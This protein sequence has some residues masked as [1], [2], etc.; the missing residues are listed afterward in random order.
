RRLVDHRLGR[1]RPGGRRAEAAGVAVVAES[2]RGRASTRVHRG[3]PGVGSARGHPGPGTV[4]RPRNRVDPRLPA[5]LI[6]SSAK[7]AL[8]FFVNL[9]AVA[10]LTWLERRVSA[11][12]QDRR[13]P[14]RVGPFG[15]LQPLADGIKFIFK[16]EIPPP[17]VD[18]PVTLPAPL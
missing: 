17:Q 2:R 9:T 5:L 8:I 13:G 12:I 18:R 7:I 10:Y 15:L 3:G 1:L 6:E 4:G 14:N 16:E 11:W